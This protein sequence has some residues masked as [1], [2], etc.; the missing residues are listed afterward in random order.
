MS[1]VDTE[2]IEKISL[3]SM[4][5]Y[6][7]EMKR[8][9]LVILLFACVV[10]SCL[11]QSNKNKEKNT[12]GTKFEHSGGGYILPPSDLL[13]GIQP[14]ANW[15]WDSGEIN[16]K[17]YFLHVRKSLTL[18]NPVQEARAFISAAAGK[19]LSVCPATI[20]IDVL[21]VYVSTATL[22]RVI[23]WAALFVSISSPLPSAFTKKPLESIPTPPLVGNPVADG[24][25]Q[26]PPKTF[27]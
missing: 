7:I 23:D 22:L 25:A 16:P 19:M 18:N 13:D 6:L 5:K 21:F 3:K 24:E 2:F 11:Q 10:E 8:K 4:F 12:D 1:K 17:N 15:I 9:I 26:P 27:M 14:E 20:V